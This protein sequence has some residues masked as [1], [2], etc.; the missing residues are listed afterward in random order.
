MDKTGDLKCIKCD[1]SL[2]TGIY[3]SKDKPNMVDF[4][5]ST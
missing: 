3:V 2:Y 5:Q 1:I 4:K